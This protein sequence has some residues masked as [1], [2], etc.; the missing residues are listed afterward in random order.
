[1]IILYSLF[2]LFNL[3]DATMTRYALKKGYQEHMRF[4]K[5][6]IDEIGLDKAMIL[7]SL[8]PTPFIVLIFLGWENTLV[9]FFAVV[10]FLL[11]S[12]YYLYVFIHNFKQLRK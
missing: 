9:S 4:T 2:V 12:M 5:V 6:V 1:M 3:I 8:L 11:F 7:K 10:L